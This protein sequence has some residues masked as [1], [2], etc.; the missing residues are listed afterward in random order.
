MSG[1]TSNAQLPTPN[2]QV[3]SRRGYTNW[4]LGVRRWALG[5]FSFPLLVKELTEAAARRRTYVLRVVYAVLLYSLFGLYAPHW[6]WRGNATAMFAMGAGAQMFGIVVTVQLCGIALFLPA[7]MCGRI[8][9][10]KERDSLVLLFLT[11]LRPWQIVLQKYVGGLVP[12][13]SFLLLSMPLAAIAYAFGGVS[14]EHL[15][16]GIYTLLLAC[17]Q[18]GALALMLS[19]WCRST[20]AAFIATYFLATVLYVGPPLATQF[21]V[22]QYL[23]SQHSSWQFFE[24]SPLGL[25]G[26]Q[27]LLGASNVFSSSIPILIS[28]AV[29]LVAARVFLV[30][31]AFVPPSNRFL[32]IFRRLDAFM[33][34]AN[35]RVGNVMVLRETRSLPG[36]DPVAWRE[37]TRHALGKP[38]YLIRVLV[39]IEIPVIFLCMLMGAE[40][41][42]YQRDCVALSVLAALAGGLAVL[43]LSGRA[44][45]AF[46]A[47]RVNQTIDVLLTTPLGAREIVAQKARVLRRFM[48]VLAIPLATIF[49][50]ELW[51]EHE[52]PGWGSQS[53]QPLLYATCAAVALLVYLPLVSWLSLWIGLKM[54]TRFKAII[55]AVAVIVA[56]CAVPWVAMVG[57]SE[58]M[59]PSRV[60]RSSMPY[61]DSYYDA[62][63]LFTLLSPVTA[64]GLNELPYPNP[65]NLYSWLPMGANFIFY[66]ACLALF[67]WLALARADRYLRG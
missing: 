25:L 23:I 26:Y 42:G 46:V 44:A 51:L 28:I 4:T 18:L 8:T 16:A 9:Q 39:C 35:R 5:V 27:R 10:E 31:R 37:M 41:P 60:M 49:G 3:K 14:P 20:V 43:A 36:D 56:W 66:A 50:F 57:V 30:R 38:H 1:E 32:R 62:A 15:G 2:S 19:A 53:D 34:R 6:L 21:L 48:L 65:S 33:Q 7:L 63:E 17:L 40:P 29:F 45:N 52:L 61:R 67:R 24:L 12:M 59:E 13:L 11:E 47:E 54:K 58:W 55:T 22:S 64:V